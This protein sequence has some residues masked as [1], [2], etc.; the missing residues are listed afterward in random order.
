MNRA[1]SAL[2][3]ALAV[4]TCGGCASESQSPATTT[5]PGLPTLARPALTTPSVSPSRP[6]AFASPS[7]SAAPTSGLLGDTYTVQPGDTLSSIAARYYND[8]SEWRPIFEANRDR[9]PGPESLSTG[10]SLRIPPPQPTAT[11]QTTPAGTPQR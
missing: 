2:L 3:V 1:S 6:A 10:M 8:A 9:L 7:P 5:I 4:V 11:R